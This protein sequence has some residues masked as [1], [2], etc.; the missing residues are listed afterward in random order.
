MDKFEV[1]TLFAYLFCKHKKGEFS[2]KKTLPSAIT[3]NL[4]LPV[5]AA[6]MFLVSGPQLVTHCCQN[7]IIGSFPFQNA[8]T[9]DI[10][11]SWLQDITE[12][13]ASEPNS[14]VWAANIVV[15]SSYDRMEQ[16]LELVKQYKPPIV[17]TALGDPTRVIE[18]VHSYG[19]L[20][21]ADVNSVRFA[22]KAVASGVDGLVL[23]CSGA[24]GH[25]GALNSFA[26]FEEVRTFWDGF[27]CLAGGMSTGASVLACEALGVD[28]AYVGTKFIVAEESLASEAN[29]NMLLE[30]TSEDI[31]LTDSFTG[32]PANILRQSIEKEGLDP[33]NLKKKD[34]IH[35]DQPLEGTKVWKDIWSAVHGVN[36]LKSIQPVAQ[37]IQEIVNEYEEAKQNLLLQKIK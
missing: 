29:K 8:R 10:L 9:I 22:K 14:T 36:Q 32:V 13:L 1:G 19:G 34:R 30:D 3:K 2:L 15:H 35:F 27:I 37:I 17:I 21:F 23:V 11:K 18:A 6:P 31:I 16:E 28:F 12:Q 26:F 24:G 4:A 20:V 5:I 33:D 7:G 25:T